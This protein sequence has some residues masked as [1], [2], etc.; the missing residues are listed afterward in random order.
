MHYETV[1]LKYSQY[2]E[3]DKQLW[4]LQRR[5]WHPHV[6]LSHVEDDNG[7]TTVI[8]FKVYDK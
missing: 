2:E 3:F 6:C 7:F 5:D 1:E 8:T 4:E